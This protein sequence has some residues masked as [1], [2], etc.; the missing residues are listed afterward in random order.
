MTRKRKYP[1]PAQ[2]P[3]ET[4]TAAPDLQAVVAQEVAKELDRVM[5]SQAPQVHL[6]VICD[7]PTTNQYGKLCH[8]CEK[9]W[10][11]IPDENTAAEYQLSRRMG[12]LRG[13]RTLGLLEIL[14][15]SAEEAL[16]LNQ[17]QL[18]ARWDERTRFC[19]NPKLIEG[20][21][22][23]F[24]TNTGT[25]RT[26]ETPEAQRIYK[27]QP[28]PKTETERR[29]EREAVERKQQDMARERSERS[30]EMDRIQAKALLARAQQKQAALSGGGA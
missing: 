6:C 30:I 9:S 12:K 3:A 26:R 4:Q 23:G 7:D 2:A 20:Q 16:K 15:L 21:D 25:L 1:N 11:A 29:T 27:S 10:A 13:H 24:N 17:D 28:R 8:R 22:R 18:A 19:T 14:G 5:T